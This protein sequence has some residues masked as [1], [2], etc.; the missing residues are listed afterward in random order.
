M[1]SLFVVGLLKYLAFSS[2]EDY[3][4]TLIDVLQRKHL[5]MEKGVAM[6][7]YMFHYNRKKKSKFLSKYSK[8][9]RIFKKVAHKLRIE[10]IQTIDTNDE[11][12]MKIK[13]Q[14]IN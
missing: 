7:T 6:L 14:M 2:G 12:R 8:E 1:S 13:N 4:Y 10:K 11:I 9:K 5:M 3:S